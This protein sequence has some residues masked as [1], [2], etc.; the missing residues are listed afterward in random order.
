MP[1]SSTVLDHYVRF[2]YHVGDQSLPDAFIRI[3]KRLTVGDA[4]KMLAK[5][6]TV[7]MLEVLLQRHVYAKPLELKSNSELRDAV[8]FLLDLF[9]ENG[10]SASFRMRDDFVTPI[11]IG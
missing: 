8:L 9:V 2:L 10:S 1:P 4:K 6:N 7:F 3:A 5:S 11:S